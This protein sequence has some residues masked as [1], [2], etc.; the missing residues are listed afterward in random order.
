MNNKELVSQVLIKWVEM[1]RAQ[2]G[3]HFATLEEVKS[4]KSDPL[5]SLELLKFVDA[6]EVMR[7]VLDWN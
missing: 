1:K 7:I 5:G 3:D 2:Q 6:Y 4:I